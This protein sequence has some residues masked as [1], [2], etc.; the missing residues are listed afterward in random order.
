MSQKKKCLVILNGP[1]VVNLKNF[2]SKEDNILED[3]DLIGVN[4]WVRIFDLLGL[5]WPK[6][7][8]VGKNSLNYNGPFI[9]KL[10]QT[11]FYGIDRLKFPAKNYR[12]IK[13]GKMT[14]YQKTIDMKGAL[15][16]SGFYAIQLALQKEY[17]EIHVF[18]F[19]CTNQPDYADTFQ[20]AGIRPA[21]YHKIIAFLQELNEKGL[22]EKIHF[23]E[24]MTNHPFRHLIVSDI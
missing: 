3:F 2:L 10:P 17:E 14:V 18:G 22:M 6:Y 5:T 19:T 13:T 24:N 16:W 9:R 21:N 20:R 23:Y 12:L 8:V 1:S 11:T 7:I 15:W 4:R